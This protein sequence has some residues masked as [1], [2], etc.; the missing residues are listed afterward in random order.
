MFKK[1]GPKLLG[2]YKAKTKVFRGCIRVHL[3]H[4]NLTFDKMH[5]GSQVDPF[6]IPSEVESFL[7]T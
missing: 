3:D 4:K 2:Y 5:Q 1:E 7:L 6:E